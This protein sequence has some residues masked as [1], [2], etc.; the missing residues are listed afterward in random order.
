MEKRNVL[1]IFGGVSGEHE[2]SLISARAIFSHI[3]L[4]KYTPIPLLITQDGKWFTDENSD[5]LYNKNLEK[6]IQVTLPLDPEINSLMPVYNSKLPDKLNKKIDCVFPILHGTN[7]ED[8]TIQGLLTLLEI[9]FVGSG[10]GGSFLGMDKEFMKIVFSYKGLP[11]VNHK[12]MRFSEWL[13]NKNVLLNEVKSYLNFPFFIKPCNLGSSVGISKVDEINDLN[14]AID[15]AFQYDN[16]II[17]EEGVINAREFEVSVI[18][19]EMPRVS[20]VGEIIPSGEFYDYHSKYVDESSKIIVP[21]DIPETLEKEI[22]VLSKKAFQ[23]LEIYGLARVDFLCNSDAKLYI[24]ELNTLPGFTPIS[25]YPK[26]LMHQ[27]Y[28]FKKIISELIELAFDRFEKTSRVK[29]RYE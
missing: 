21:A 10:V 24:N 5:N 18:G 26:L 9:P 11:V 3:D 25:M 4:E 2:I 14:K 15:K 6:S 8:G 19:N 7:G 23:S 20:L 13:N 1:I 12:I 28:T 17:I 29:K 27:G 22:K 16:K